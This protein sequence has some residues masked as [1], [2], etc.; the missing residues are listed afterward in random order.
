MS[1][2][3]RA[4]F[5]YSEIT[6]CG[7]CKSSEI[8]L[9]HDFGKVPLAGY[10]P[11]SEERLLPLVPMQLHRC[12]S[13]TLYQISPDISDSYLFSNYRYVSSIGM[14]AH[15]NEFALW[16]SENENA[17]TNVKIA[18]LG[19]NDGP[20][21][22]ALNRLG[23]NPT[24]IDPA[25]NIVRLAREKGLAVINDFF[26][27]SAVDKYTELQDLDYLFSSNS[28]A[29]I[30]QIQEVAEAVSM[31][32][33]ESGRFIVEVQSFNSLL[34]NNAF[35]F[36]YH[37]HKYYYTLESMTNLMRQFGLHLIDG[38]LTDA[39]GGS[40]RLIF[41]KEFDNQSERVRNLLKS[42]REKDFGIDSVRNA[43]SQYLTQLAALDQFVDKQLSIGQKIIA[44]GASGRANMLLGNLP[45]T[46]ARSIKVIDES[47]ERINRLMAQNKNEVV[48][49]QE[50][51]QNDYDY[52]LVLAWNFRNSIIDKWKNEKTSFITPLPFFKVL[53][54]TV[55]R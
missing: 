29:H 25:V 45:L 16:F 22:E 34:A 15:F 55:N 43:I 32:L 23:Y 31:A 30:N 11:T 36:V 4:E 5:Q 40:Y 42:E 33:S 19:C 27:L 38:V 17:A 2:H 3:Q 47:P 48:S 46:R 8:T 41:S 39:H 26:S 37:E 44:F 28:F 50:I 18:E 54:G 51:N 9:V 49:F 1:G 35:D 7:S 20:F 12:K 13:C 6:N 14:Q 53:R 21:L 24:G 52:V 10:F